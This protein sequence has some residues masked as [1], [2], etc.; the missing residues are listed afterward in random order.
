MLKRVLIV[1]GVFAALFVV[2]KLIGFD[3]VWARV[4]GPPDLGP[5]DFRGLEKGPK[6]NQALVCPPQLCDPASV[7]VESPVYALDAKRLAQAA[8]SALQ[9]LP[10]SERVDDGSQDTTLRFVVRTSLMQFPD[11]VVV[12]AVEGTAQ[13]TAHIAIYSRS[14]IGYSDM[15][16]NLKRVRAILASLAQHEAS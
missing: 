16:A 3:N 9:A 14:Q 11:T 2:G 13:G 7:D 8:R 12:E 10:G 5:V 1:V 4:A 15:G 6:P